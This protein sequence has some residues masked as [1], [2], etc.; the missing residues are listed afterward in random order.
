VLVVSG[1]Q[2]GVARE[3]GQTVCLISADSLP[4]RAA[5]SSS[6]WAAAWVR[7]G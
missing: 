7:H 1:E 6:V 4:R 3:D 5:H 2:L